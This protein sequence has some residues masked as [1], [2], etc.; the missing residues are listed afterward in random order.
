MLSQRKPKVF[1]Y[2]PRY[3]NN[4]TNDVSENT[5]TAIKHKWNE[6]RNNKKSRGNM[7]TS[8]PLLLFFLIA[9]IILIFVLNRYTD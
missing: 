9:V 4:K 5:S 1:G 3:K 7:F 6:I 8:L 2:Q